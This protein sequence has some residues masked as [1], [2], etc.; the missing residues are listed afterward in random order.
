MSQLPVP[1]YSLLSSKQCGLLFRPATE[2]LDEGMVNINVPGQ[3]ASANPS[4]PSQKLFYF[5]T[6][7]QKSGKSSGSGSGSTRG[8]GGSDSP[9][10]LSK[11]NSV[12][13]SEEEV[14][15]PIPGVRLGPLLGKGSFG[16]V[17]YGTWNGA[18]IAVKVRDFVWI[19]LLEF[20]CWQEDCVVKPWL[21]PVD[22]TSSVIELVPC[23]PAGMTPCCCC[24]RTREVIPLELLGPHSFL[25]VA[26][27]PSLCLI[28]SISPMANSAAAPRTLF[29]ALTPLCHPL[30][31]CCPQFP[32]PPPGNLQQWSKPTL[33][34][35]QHMATE[36]EKQAR[37]EQLE[38]IL[39]LKMMHP[40]IVRTFQFATK[41]RSVRRRHLYP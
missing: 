9:G 1:C 23:F 32:V 37:D 3:A 2:A 35:I 40:N 21:R 14:K 6:I 24:S 16:S 15:A 38:A 11:Q 34:V 41:D 17:H 27:T 19:R 4:T 18:Q 26:E 25:H 7:S 10:Q 8:E 33:Q 13:R 28:S 12:T 5:G 36:A 29:L 31:Y 22:K 30:C 39:G 20:G